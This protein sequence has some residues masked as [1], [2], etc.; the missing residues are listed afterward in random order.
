MPDDTA[1]LPA[2]A[3]SV[4]AAALAGLLGQPK[5]LPP[6]LF[7]DE[8]GCRLFAQITDLPEYYLTRTERALLDK[9][10]P[11]VLRSRTEPTVLV[12]YGA[13]DEGKAEYLLNVSDQSGEPVIRAYVPIDVAA[14]ALR[15]M[16]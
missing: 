16:S 14:P 8:A 1:L 5:T 9:V 7:Y 11:Q 15:R 4:A 2:A 3:S 13:S 12:E 10:A 6:A